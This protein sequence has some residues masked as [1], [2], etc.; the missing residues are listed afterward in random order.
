MRRPQ[1]RDV[2]ERQ[3]DTDARTR[4]GAEGHCPDQDVP[5]GVLEN[6]VAVVSIP[7]IRWQ[8]CDIKSLA[9]LPN[10]LGKQRAVEQGAK[11]VSA[12][13]AALKP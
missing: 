10:V 7:D 5:A 12:P 3:D 6:G 2:R 4:R 1:F 8:R 9:L 11:R 13:A